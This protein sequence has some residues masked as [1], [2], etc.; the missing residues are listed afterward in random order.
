MLWLGQLDF[1]N[2]KKYLSKTP[3][4]INTTLPSC[5]HTHLTLIPSIL[6]CVNG[7]QI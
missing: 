2:L 1:N 4:T 5:I 6:K 3:V 7:V